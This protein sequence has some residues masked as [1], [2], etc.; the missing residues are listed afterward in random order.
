MPSPH[1]YLVDG[2]SYI[3]RAFHVL[4]PLTN[5]FGLSVGAG[6]G[7][8]AMLWKLADSLNKE[9]GPT[10]LAVIL[11]ASEST[12]R[13]SSDIN[14]D[15]YQEG[16]P[17]GTRGGMLLRHHFPLDAEYTFT[18]KL[19]RTHHG[20][21]RG[22]EHPNQLEITVDGERVHSARIGG[23]AQSMVIGLLLI[24]SLLVSNSTRYL[25]GWLRNI[26]LPIGAG[27]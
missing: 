11:D 19:F 17:L 1:L 4:P 21:V 23:D 10:H 24:G 25:V 7:Y 12:F 5:K 22:L 8:T 3:F 26:G 2:S 16:L 18:V 14:Q 27:G 20:V 13:M 9:D 6:Y 15:D